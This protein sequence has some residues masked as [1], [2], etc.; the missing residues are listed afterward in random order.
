MKDDPNQTPEFNLPYRLEESRQTLERG[1]MEDEQMQQIHAQLM[2]EK[3]EPTEGFSPTPIFFI[4]LF[5]A[6]MFWGGI[7][8]ISYSGGFRG[9]VFNPDW[10]PTAS[11]SSEAVVVAFDPL[12]HGAKLFKRQCQQCHQADAEGIPGVY[13]PLSKS[14]WI[15]GLEDRIIKVLLLGMAGPIT[16]EGHE[17]N[18]NMPAVNMWSDKDIAA[19]LTYVRANFGNN[20]PAVSEEKVKTIRKELGDRHAPWTPAE[21]LKIHPF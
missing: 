18:G 4:F 16:V 2:R 7:Y 15:N 13:P 12:K 6:L 9:D 3:E 10:K 5:G 20:A 11:G 8:L 1:A 17:F 14:E 21:L 19:V